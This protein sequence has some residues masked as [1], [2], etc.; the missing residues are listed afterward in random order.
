[1]TSANNLSD[2]QSVEDF[3]HFLLQN[4]SSFS[5]YINN[6][7]LLGLFDSH[8]MR[9]SM[10]SIMAQVL[11]NGKTKDSFFLLTRQA[12]QDTL[13]L[14]FITRNISMNNSLEFYLP[15]LVE[16]LSDL[17][18]VERCSIFLYDG[19]KDQ[20]FCKVITGRLREPINFKRESQNVI[21]SVFN[22]GL[23]KHFRKAQ[24]SVN[25]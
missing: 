7:L 10:I 16:M 8:L 18:D 20:L 4:D 2:L 14:F 5:D 24:D 22:T 21:S 6:P 17:L 11:G 19:V 1:M 13:G 15:R 23:P 12:I 25:S 3:R 9:E